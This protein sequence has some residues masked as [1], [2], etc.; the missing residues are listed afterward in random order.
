MKGI[1]VYGA[2]IRVGGFSGYLCELLTLHHGSFTEFLRSIADWREN[3]IIDYE[4]HYKGREQKTRKIFEEPLVVVD[5]V[6]K[7]RNAAAA[8]RKERLDELIVASRAF[9]TKPHQEFFYP[10]A[11]AAYT[12]EKLVQAITT[13]GSTIVFVK[14]GRVRAVPDIL[15]GQLYKSQR[16]LKKMLQ[17]HDFNI[18]RNH[19][20]SDERDLNILIFE[21][22]Q[23]FLPLIKKHMGPPTEKRKECDK[24]LRKHV[25]VANTIS[26]PRIEGG[27]W[28]VETKR[29][30][31]DIVNLLDEKLKDGGRRVGVADLISQAV[32]N[33]LDILVNEEITKLY[34]SNVEFA[35][36]LTEYLEGKPRW[37]SG[38]DEE[39]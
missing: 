2:E 16:A 11:T 38:I 19:I 9:L 37:L 25:G 17:Q 39:N 31:T 23:R 34:S 12:P 8:V 6:D 1:G 18:I 14:F 22:E 20:W 21:A 35:K 15:W 28:V 7:G 13:R 29:R 36:F 27:R 26:G 32:A 24:F 30:Y 10:G 3:R 5:P 33:T 4:G